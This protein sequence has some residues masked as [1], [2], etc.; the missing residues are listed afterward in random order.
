MAT[1]KQYVKKDGKKAWQFQAYLGTDTMTGK[2]IRTTRR[3]FKTKKEATLALSRLQYEITEKGFSK[4]QYYTFKEVYEIWLPQYKQTVKE[5][6]YWKTT[7][8]FEHHISPLFSDLRIDKIDVP[9]C[10]KAVEK[11]FNDGLTGYKLIFR[12]TAKVFKLAANMDIIVNDP[13]TKVT[14]PVKRETRVIKKAPNFY[15]KAELQIFLD[16]L[17][18]EKNDKFIALYRSLAFTGARIGEILALE[19][20]DIDFNASTLSVNKTLTRGLNNRL[21]VDVPKTVSSIRTISLDPK[22]LSIL[23]KWKMKQTEKYFM[24]GFNTSSSKQLVFSNTKNEHMNSGKV[25]K[26]YIKIVEKYEL[27][28]IKI[29]G[30]RHTFSSLLFESGA[31]IKEVQEILGHSNYE[32]TLDIYTHVTE[33]A[34]EKTTSKFANYIDF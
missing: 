32:I 27:K 21:M 15:N 2:E 5:S 26:E 31:S 3:G 17:E 9:Y 4:T 6:S 14:Y 29:H 8:L 22:T 13:T 28:K 18:K 33:E 10:Q 12:Y 7:R 1:F 25:Y 20:R 24:L 16:C 19:W 23:K 30:F 11:W 34:K